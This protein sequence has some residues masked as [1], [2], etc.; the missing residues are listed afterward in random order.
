MWDLLF[1]L[2]GVAALAIL[3]AGAAL[4]FYLLHKF[5]GEEASVFIG[6]ILSAYPAFLA[7]RKIEL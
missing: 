5:I 7:Y 6:F 3:L 4:S 2:G 1:H